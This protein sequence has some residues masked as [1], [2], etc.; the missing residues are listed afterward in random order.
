[1]KSFTPAEI[2]SLVQGGAHLRRILAAVAQMVKPGVSGIELNAAAEKLIAA[3]GAKPAFK[4]YGQP[5]YPNALCVSINDCVVH[6]IAQQQPLKQGDIVSLDCGIEYQ[7]L[8][9]DAATTIPVGKISARASDLIAT[10]KKS[11]DLAVKTLR[12]GIT[13]GDLGATV[14]AFVEQQ[15][16]AVVREYTGHGVGHLVHDDPPI[17][18]FGQPGQGVRL[19]LGMVIAIEPMITAG[20]WKVRVRDNQWDVV[21]V[22]GSLAAHFEHTVVITSDGCRV[23]T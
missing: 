10:A 5:P 13:T 18:N 17:P 14:Q 21:T 4:G 12:A 15:G 22:D 20:D 16:F 8:F 3:A 7:G 1:M 11:L 23:L 19:T 9:T 2:E 6:G